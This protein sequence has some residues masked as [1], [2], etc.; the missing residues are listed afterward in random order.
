M[1]VYSLIIVPFISFSLSAAGVGGVV[2]GLL[3]GTALGVALDQLGFGEF[4]RRNKWSALT[5]KYK[6]VV[7]QLNPSRSQTF[8]CDRVKSVTL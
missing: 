7:P 5:S 2:S 3:G 6:T 4:D 1:S 8:S